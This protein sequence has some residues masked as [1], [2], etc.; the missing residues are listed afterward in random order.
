VARASALGVGVL[1]GGG[2]VDLDLDVFAAAG[3]P[4]VVPRAGVLP[5]ERLLGGGLDDPRSAGGFVEPTGLDVV[6]LDLEAGD[7]DNIV[8]FLAAEVEA[9]VAFDDP[10]LEG[11]DE[12]G[13]GVVGDKQAVAAFA[14]FGSADDDA[15]LDGPLAAGPGVPAVE[16]F[17]VEE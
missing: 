2:A 16:G 17:A 1:G 10:V 3:Q 14:G 8:L 5:L 7:A 13:E 11:D 12:V 4:D 9:A 6:D 15:V